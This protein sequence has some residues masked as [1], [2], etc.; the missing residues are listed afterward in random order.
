MGTYIAWGILLLLFAALCAPLKLS[1]QYQ[2]GFREVKAG[3]L[4][5]WYKILPQ[6][7]KK[8]VSAKKAERIRRKDE[9]KAQKM[10]KKAQKNS[11]TLAPE[12]KP[13]AEK[14]Q[15]RKEEDTQKKTEA[16]TPQDEPKDRQSKSLVQ[17]V[18]T[19]L[20]VVRALSGPAKFFYRRIKLYKLRFVL[21]ISRG[22]A[23]ETAIAFG[24]M[25]GWVHGAYAVLSHF[26][27]FR[28]EKILVE[29]DYLNGKDKLFAEGTVK[30]RP[31]WVLLF[32]L[33]TGAVLLW[34]LVLRKEKSKPK[35]H[36]EKE[37]AA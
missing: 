19:V 7:P 6:K 32:A 20:S 18:E 15:K 29:I 13:R 11:E 37:I 5:L 34:K 26:V 17:T 10:Q 2:D 30:V 23:A 27:C 28:K 21:T 9:K 31:L 24:Q 25:N 1:V 35:K 12:E 36:A 33:T 4:F 22:D 3:W 8:E 14:S 16:Q